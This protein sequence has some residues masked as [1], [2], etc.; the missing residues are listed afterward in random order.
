MDLDLIDLDVD[1]VTN[2][3]RV[4]ILMNL[5]DQRVTL[6]TTIAELLY[7]GEEDYETQLSPGKV[8]LPEWLAIKL[9]LV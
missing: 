1:V 6:N 9:E 4:M 7:V 3:P 5:K 2:N 8:Q